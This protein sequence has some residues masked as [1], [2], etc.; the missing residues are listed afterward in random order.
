MS[1]GI[2]QISRPLRRPLCREEGRNAR[3]AGPSH[4]PHAD[5][6]LHHG[7]YRRR[8]MGHARYSSRMV[9]ESKSAL[10]PLRG[11]VQYVDPWNLQILP[12]DSDLD[13]Q[14]SEETIYFL[15]KYYNMTEYHFPLPDLSAGRNYLLEVN[16]HYTIRGTE[17]KFNVIDAR[18]I[19]TETG[20]FIDI[21][22]IRKNWTAIENGVEGAL[23]C[24]DRHHYLASQHR[25]K[26]PSTPH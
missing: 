20:L 5:L 17:D 4:H 18:W 16:P 7:R 22:T 15:A 9:V 25:E 11:P 14:V 21:S 6:P 24:K 2:G 8:D 19:D 26:Q 12:W 13:L 3:A 23:M 10:Q 1:N